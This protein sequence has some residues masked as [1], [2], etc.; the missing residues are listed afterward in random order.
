[1]HPEGLDPNQEAMTYVGEGRDRRK[2]SPIH[3]SIVQKYMKAEKYAEMNYFPG[4]AALVGLHIRYARAYGS[5]RHDPIITSRT[6]GGTR[7]PSTN[8]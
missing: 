7:W 2:L 1:M 3:R 6:R 8:G 5:N 4:K